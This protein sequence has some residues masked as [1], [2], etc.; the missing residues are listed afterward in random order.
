MYAPRVFVSIIGTLAVFAV[1][2]Y[3]IS[4]SFLTALTE[5]VICAVILQIGYFL[6]ILYLVRREAQEKSSNRSPDAAA[7]TSRPETPSRE[8][9]TADAAARMHLH[10]R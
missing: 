1:A 4:G 3:L 7:N 6:G 9:I 5:T 8:T 10:D 2:A